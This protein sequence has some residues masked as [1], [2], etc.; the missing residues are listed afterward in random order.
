MIERYALAAT[1]A[2]VAV[3]PALGQDG[4]GISSLS[5]SRCAGKVGLETRQVDAA[6]GFIALDGMPWV[7]IERTEE[8]IGNQRISTTVTGTGARGRRDGTSVP[9]RFSCLLD[10]KG[11]ALMFH[12]SHL[13]PQLGDQLPPS[14]TINGSAAYAEKTA[15]PR[16]LELRVQLLD[17]GKSSVGE[18]LSEQVVRTGW[19]VPIPFSL[20]LP[21]DVSLDGRKIAI[22]ARMVVGRQ[23]LFQLKELVALT[24]ADLGK[25]VELTLNKEGAAKR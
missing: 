23:T 3:P 6:F 14:I 15:P 18:I 10:S 24:A 19:Q 25:P 1:L 8:R 21:K 16:G 9:F 12:A 17:I 7:T 13:L 5:I 4:G 11:E 2:C 20:R 22:A